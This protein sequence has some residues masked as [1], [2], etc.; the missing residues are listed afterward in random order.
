LSP[1]VTLYNPDLPI[2]P[3]KFCGATIMKAW[4][5]IAKNGALMWWTVPILMLWSQTVHPECQG[6]CWKTNRQ[7]WPQIRSK[8]AKIQLLEIPH[9]TTWVAI[10]LAVCRLIA[11]SLTQS[12]LSTTQ[13][14][15]FLHL[16]LQLAT[17]CLQIL[18]EFWND[19][20][21]I[22]MHIKHHIHI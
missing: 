4:S 7:F 8:K 17:L 3:M 5:V 20:N 2:C 14:I 12:L 6:R 19:F 22:Y 18:N 1:L 21:S 13:L 11:P 16:L 9:P 15:Q 10:M